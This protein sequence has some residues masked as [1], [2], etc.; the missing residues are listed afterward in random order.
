[1]LRT[2]DILLLCVVLAGAVEPLCDPFNLAPSDA[3]NFYHLTNFRTHVAS[4]DSKNLMTNWSE[5][6]WVIAQRHF[7]RA[8]IS[9]SAS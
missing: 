2:T 9:L 5:L 3:S 1:M 4:P 6:K 8:D 7:L